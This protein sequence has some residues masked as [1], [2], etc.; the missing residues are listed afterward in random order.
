ME[1]EVVVVVERKEI[2]LTKNVSCQGELIFGTLVEKGRPSHSQLNWC[3][4]EWSL[5]YSLEI[6]AIERHVRSHLDL[7]SSQSGALLVESPQRAGKEG[8]DFEEWK[9]R[10][11][12]E[13]KG[14]P[15]L[16]LYL[17]SGL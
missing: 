17:C 16:E 2:W 12:E 3:K 5:S 13:K 7:F 14:H 8:G 4:A 6:V 9:K 11:R 1:E 15:A 10:R